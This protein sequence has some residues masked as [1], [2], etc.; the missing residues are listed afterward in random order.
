MTT[1]TADAQSIARATRSIL[2]G[3]GAQLAGRKRG[4]DRRVRRNSF[5]IDD[6]R[7]RV[8]RP[9]NGG[10]K[11]AGLR[12]SDT[13]LKLAKEYDLVGKQKG[14]M[15]PLGPHTVRVL[16]ILLK[17]LVDFATGRLEPTYAELMRRTGYAKST[18]ASALRRLRVHGFLDWVRRSR[19]VATDE[20]EVR[21]QTSNAIFFDLSRMPKRAWLRFQ[22][23]LARRERAAGAAVAA[24]QRP[25]SPDRPLEPA[26][27]ELRAAL[28][29]LQARIDDGAE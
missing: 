14:R 15:G 18:I 27:P 17:D 19:I 2:K 16:E 8:W 4:P 3:A 24:I 12:W 23:L 10:S 25:P 21:H 11:P 1:G 6:P 28:S 29:R 5:D 26:D 7:S 13:M 22:Q 9:I 20:G